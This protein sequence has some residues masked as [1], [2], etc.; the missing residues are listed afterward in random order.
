M[1]YVIG[2]KTDLD[3]WQ[4]DVDAGALHYN[5]HSGCLCEHVCGDFLP[6]CLQRG[7]GLVVDVQVGQGQP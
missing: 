6:W 4:G 2:V 1:K 3:T 5:P 7:L